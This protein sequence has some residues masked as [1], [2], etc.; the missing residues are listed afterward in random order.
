LETDA[1]YYSAHI[2][3]NPLT[4]EE[5]RAV[6]D[7]WRSE[8]SAPL[9]ALNPASGKGADSSGVHNDHCSGCQVGAM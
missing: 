1:V 8:Q 7:A 5:A 4:L 2:E 3:G 6:I 9:P